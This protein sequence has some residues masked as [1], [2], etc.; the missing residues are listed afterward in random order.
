MRPE[1]L[2]LLLALAAPAGAWAGT[3]DLVRLGRIATTAPLCGLRDEPW[4]FDLRRAA[5]Q[6]ATSSARFDDRA[7]EAAPGS[8]QAQAALGYAEM[9][10]LED[11]AEAPPAQTCGPL[12]QS[13]DLARADEV[14]RAFRAQRPGS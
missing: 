5:L 8:D 4:A 2:M 14:V 13:P 7:L 3:E 6:S 11:F 10:A 1:R 12:A 9:E